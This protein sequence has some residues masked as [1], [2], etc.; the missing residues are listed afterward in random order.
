M[1]LATQTKQNQ[2]ENPKR[3]NTLIKIGK[4]IIWAEEMGQQEWGTRQGDRRWIDQNALYRILE[5]SQ[6]S[7][8]HM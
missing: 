3:K 7:L 2:K 6:E 1:Q 5:N 4:G 8:Y